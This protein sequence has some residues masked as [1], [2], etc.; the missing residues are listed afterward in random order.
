M[1]WRNAD[2]SV[3]SKQFTCGHCGNLVAS[4]I[5]YLR[6]DLGPDSSCLRICPH[7]MKPTYF[8]AGKQ[9]PGVAPGEVVDHLPSDIA[10]LYTEARSAIAANAFTASVLASRKLL[11]HIA[12]AKGAPKD[13]KFIEYVEFLEK[14]H[15]VPPGGKQW[16]DHIRQMGNEANHEIKLMTRET[17]EELVD[18]SG[19]LLKFIFEFPNRVPKRTAA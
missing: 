2:A 13:S 6:S 5:G 14:N 9:L 1:S 3:G 18:F 15:Y 7:C 10:G 12:E 19:M 4:T 11:M 8:E 16:V 17:A